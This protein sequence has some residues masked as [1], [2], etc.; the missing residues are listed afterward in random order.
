IGDEKIIINKVLGVTLDDGEVLTDKGCICVNVQTLCALVDA[1]D[2]GLPCIRRVI[3]CS[4][5][6]FKEA[7]NV[8]VKVGSIYE[9]VV[10]AV[11]GEKFP[12]A[13]YKQLEENAKCSY[14]NYLALRDEFKQDES[15][16]EIKTEMVEMRKKANDEIIE[17]LK[18]EKLYSRIIADEFICGGGYFSGVKKDNL[19]F[20]ITKTS[21]S[22]LLLTKG[23]NKKREKLIKKIKI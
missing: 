6:A 12:L 18:A 16:E 19:E 3:T 23:E 2:Y 14:G 10:T 22:I 21:L 20:A 9:D 5:G 7:C 11:G 4:G 1:V 15:D 17:F 8:S 13:K